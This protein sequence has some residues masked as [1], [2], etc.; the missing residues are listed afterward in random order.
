MQRL[1]DGDLLLLPEASGVVFE[2]DT[3]R[4]IGPDEP[5]EPEVFLRSG[6]RRPCD[7]WSVESHKAV[8]AI[9]LR[10]LE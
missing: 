10:V 6:G 7:S 9:Q 4:A 5:D 3:M 1:L 2:G 8:D